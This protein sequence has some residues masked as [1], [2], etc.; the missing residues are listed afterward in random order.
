MRTAP[1]VVMLPTNFSELGEP[2]LPPVPVVAPTD[3]A[4]PSPDPL[5]VE[6]LVAPESPVPLVVVALLAVVPALA[7]VVV[8]DVVEEEV[9][10][11]SAPPAP[12]SPPSPPS[13]HPKRVAT[14][15]AIPVVPHSH[16]EESFLFILDFR[17]L[18]D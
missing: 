4:P 16:L 9:V 13:E 18:D 17:E 2:P 12:P 15:S 3:P 1:F 11:L 14:P 7:L 6:E 5:A 10:V 8:A